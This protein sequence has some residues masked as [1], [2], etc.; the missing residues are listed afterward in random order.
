M[1][2]VP[3]GL[4]PLPEALVATACTEYV[5]PGASPEIGTL[6]QRYPV[7]A[8][9]VTGAVRTE[10]PPAGT[11]SNHIVVS[12]E[13]GCTRALSIALVSPVTV[14]EVPVIAGGDA[15][16][17]VRASLAVHPAVSVM[18]SRTVRVPALKVWR[19]SAGGAPVPWASGVPSPKLTVH[20]A[21]PS[22]EL[23]PPPADADASSSTASGAAPCSV[24]TSRDAVVRPCADA[25]A[26]MSENACSDSALESTH[27]GQLPW[28]EKYE[29]ALTSG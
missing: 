19:R 24:L 23:C 28:L 5:V 22:P 4:A 29:T 11:S 9:T 21:M 7:W 25:A 8:T 27:H 18:V 1:V 15:A 14:D 6:I 20:A 13:C 17:M 16:T 3:P 12:S 26:A 10:P 2:N